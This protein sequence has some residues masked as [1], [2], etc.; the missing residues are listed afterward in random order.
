MA[1]KKFLALLEIED[2]GLDSKENPN[3]PDAVRRYMV[4]GGWQVEGEMYFSSRPSELEANLRKFFH[5]EDP[6][7]KK[8]NGLVPNQH[9]MIGPTKTYTTTI[10]GGSTTTTT[11]PVNKNGE[12]RRVFLTR[13]PIYKEPE[14][15]VSD[16]IKDIGRS[17]I[18]KDSAGT[19][20]FGDLLDEIISP[21]K[22]T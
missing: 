21:R 15:S 10:N 9:S 5:V 19:D 1:T 6:L 12:V 16:L 13:D 14:G 18:G 17:V 4:S 8:T 2:L 22:R 7:M 11:L 20:L 3:N